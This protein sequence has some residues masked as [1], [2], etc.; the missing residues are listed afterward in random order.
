M[1]REGS[2][3]RRWRGHGAGGAGARGQTLAGQAELV[4]LGAMAAG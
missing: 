4:V 1:A 3:Y 2:A